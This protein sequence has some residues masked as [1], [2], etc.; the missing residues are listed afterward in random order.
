MVQT[1]DGS[2]DQIDSLLTRMRELAVEGQNG[3]MSAND[4]TNLGTEFGQDLSEIDRVAGDAT[5]NTH[6]LLA[7]S[8]NS[9]NFQVGIQGTSNDQISVQFGGLDTSGLGL[10]GAA[11][12]SSTILTTIDNAMQT[13]NNS[14]AGFGAAMNRL[15]N[16]SNQITL[17]QT[18]LSSWRSARSRTWTLRPRPRTLLASKCSLRPVRRCSPSQSGPPAARPEAAR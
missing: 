4:L 15:Q 16:A 3:T 13:L 2:A 7:G 8:T 6:Q 14:R 9:V 17:T 1:A 10:T 5:F 11:V 12:T 18:N